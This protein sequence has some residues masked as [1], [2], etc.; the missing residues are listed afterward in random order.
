MI[1]YQA[2]YKCRLCGEEFED[3][4]TSERNARI[5]TCMLG[6]EQSYKHDELN[7]LGHRHICHFCD[8]G[9]Y[10]FSDFIGYKKVEN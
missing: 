8:D 1:E 3:Y 2:I 6:I 7:L 10:G 9:S 5:I 4:R